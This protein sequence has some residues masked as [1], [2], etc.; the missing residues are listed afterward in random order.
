MSKLLFL[1]SLTNVYT[2]ERIAL[3]VLNNPIYDDNPLINKDS[4]ER[5][6]DLYGDKLN[7]LNKK[8]I[9]A[10]TDI[11]LNI[12][13]N[14]IAKNIPEIESVVINEICTKENLY[15]IIDKNN[16]TTH[17]ALSTYAIGMANTLEI[18][19]LLQKDFAQIE[20]F[21]GGVGSVYPLLQNVVPPKNLCIGEGVNFIRK[22]FGLKPLVGRDF[23]IPM[24][25][26]NST[27]LPLSIKTYYMVTQL[28]CPHKC[29]FCITPNFY[30]HFPFSNAAK[31]IDY[32]EK[33]L[34]SNLKEIFVYLCDPNGF[35]PEKT[36]KKVFDYFIQN[37]SKTDKNIFIMGLASL[38]HI[39][40]FD[41][42]KIQEFCPIK[43]IGINYGIESTLNGGYLKNSNVAKKVIDRLNSNN[44]ISF[45]NCIIGLPIHTKKNIH[46][47]IQN[48]CSLNSDIISINTFKPIPRTQIYNEMNAQNR[49][50]LD[51]LPP[52]FLY[53]EGYLPFKHQYLGFGF[54]ILPYAFEAYYE[55]EK[56]LIDFYSNI[57]DK[58]I[59][60]YSISN[61]KSI[62]NAIKILVSLSKYN[63]ESFSQRMPSN[64]SELYKLKLNQIKVKTQ[65]F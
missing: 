57:A 29:D 60:M 44:I 21:V 56:Q 58:L 40:K 63:F 55:S 42:E 46:L 26:G 54:D 25:Y 50:L 30:D 20:L 65:N 12:E 38:E 28:G 13:G 33:L 17:I 27:N 37:R 39:N 41:I 45:H 16:D 23:K 24:I 32:F 35:Y 51:K 59:S 2:T 49:L 19:H 62:K 8:S 47:D 15:K 64:L 10:L 3:D 1:K 52:D 5:A 36:W 31:I 18:I 53:M 14:F 4:I 7:P 22:K 61:L 11:D 6:F 9:P 34:N 48:N 43:F